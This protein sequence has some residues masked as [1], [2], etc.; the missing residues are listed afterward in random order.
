MRVTFVEIHGPDSKVTAVFMYFFDLSHV[1]FGGSGGNNSD[2]AGT[3]SHNSN[4]GLLR[5]DNYLT[6]APGVLIIVDI[7][8][9]GV[10]YSSCIRLCSRLSQ[11]ESE[12]SGL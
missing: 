11:K 8:F 1:F 6:H 7:V 5:L 12:R 4:H 3:V 2:P 10:V 9:G